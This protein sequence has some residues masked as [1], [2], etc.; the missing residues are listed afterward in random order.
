MLDLLTRLID[1]LPIGVVVL[2][3]SGRAVLYNRVEEMLTGRRREDVLERDFFVEHAYCLDVPL[4][5]GHFRERI[6]RGPLDAEGDFS[7]PFPFLARP[8]EVHVQLSSFESRGAPF[9]LLL[10][11]DISHERSVEQMRQTLSQMVVHDIKN[12]LTAITGA[13]EQVEPM[14][15]DDADAREAI[16]DAFEAS[17]RIESMLLNLLDTSRLETNEFPLRLQ[18]TDVHGLAKTAVNLARTVA[19][20]NE[21]TIRLTSS[22]APVMA[23]IDP[24]VVLRIFENL[25]DNALQH[26]H[27]VTVSV[28][29]RETTTVIEVS[30]DGPGVPPDVREHIFEKFSQGQ[31]RR[32]RRA[33]RGLG[34]TFVQNAARAHGGEASLD[35]PLEGGAVFRVVL[36]IQSPLTP[37]AR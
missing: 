21:A 23:E 4:I 12:P 16:Q 26:A 9:G 14:V 29:Q 36:P 31:N 15:R 19:R 20:G 5:A 2:D 30:D 28:T 35:C 24:D 25:I 33:H 8:R 7:F 37:L 3:R 27:S 32:S 10:F 17:H 18:S 11:R 1:G 34:L 6:G 22:D 13:L